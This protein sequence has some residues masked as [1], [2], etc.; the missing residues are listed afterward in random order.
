MHEAAITQSIVDSVID[1]LSEQ[2]VTGNVTE[3]V[4][5]V[6]VS[7]GLIPESMQM[8]FDMA[9]PDTPLEEARL[10]VVVQQWS[11]TVHSAIK[12]MSSWSRSCIALNVEHQ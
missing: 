12:N 5:T 2:H 8:Y 9:V 7:Q 6:G 4:V 10:N 3:I 11:H 1:T